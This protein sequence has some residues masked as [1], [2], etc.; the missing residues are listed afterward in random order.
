MSCSSRAN[1]NRSND[2]VRGKIFF[3]LIIL[4]IFLMLCLLI[5]PSTITLC[6]AL[7]ILKPFS[8]PSG[9]LKASF[10]SAAGQARHILEDSGFIQLKRL[11]GDEMV[12]SHERASVIEKYCFLL[13]AENELCIKDISFDS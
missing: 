10:F 4:H 6:V 9:H 3:S 7:L 8:Y 2:S 12:S 13:G 11:S 5:H 1:P